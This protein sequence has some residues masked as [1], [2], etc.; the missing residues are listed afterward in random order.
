MDMRGSFLG[1]NWIRHEVNHSPPSSVEVNEYS[2]TPL[3]HMLTWHAQG[4]PFVDCTY[5]T[6]HTGRS[7]ISI[8]LVLLGYEAKITFQTP[9]LFY[10][11]TA[12]IQTHR[13]NQVF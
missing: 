8:S 4:Q 7:N 11:S 2:S 1:V 6:L 3:P 13:H 5:F 10:D 12:W 9:L